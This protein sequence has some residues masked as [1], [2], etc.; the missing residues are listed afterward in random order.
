MLPDRGTIRRYL[1]KCF[2][3]NRLYRNIRTIIDCTEIYVNNP[4]DFAKHGN[5]YS[6]YKNHTTFK[7]LIGIAPNGAFV[8]VS[9]VFEGAISDK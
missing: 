4:S 8:Y 3:S 9:D 2:I 5:L 7:I 1:P 6:S